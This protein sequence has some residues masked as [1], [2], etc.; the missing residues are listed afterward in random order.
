MIA[1]LRGCILEKHPTYL[2]LE[3]AG[4][5]YEI[6]ISVP[7]FSGLPSEGREVSLHIYTHVRED[8]LALYG[9]LRREEKQ[10]FERLISVSGIG[11][12]LAMTVLSGIAAEA[13]V[14]ALRSNDLTALT[15]VPG[16]G[17]KTAERMV[18]ELRDKLE[19]FAAQPPPAPASRM[20][21]DVVSALVNLGYQRSPAEQAVKRAIDRAGE[22]AS[23]EQLF[24]QTMSLLQK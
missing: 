20:E 3:A 1:H 6:A 5:G 19:G 10:L 15:R 7:S 12:K 2:I 14:N 11:P 8:M 4:V 9:F 22:N 16:V 18:L 23:F 24:R 21:E 17:K 13:L